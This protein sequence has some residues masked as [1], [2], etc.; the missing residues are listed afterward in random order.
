M[1]TTASEGAPTP[2]FGSHAALYARYRPRYGAALFDLAC[3]AIGPDRRLAVDLGSG[4]GQAVADLLT[5]FERVV[6]VEPDRD[7]ALRIPA[8][9]R[10]KVIQARAEDV[11]FPAGSVDLV[12]SATAFHWME[13][14][15]VCRRAARW[16]RPGGAFVAFAYG[17]A[18]VLAPRDASRLYTAAMAEWRSGV[19]ER[20]VN[21]KAYD[22]AMVEAGAFTSVTAL[23]DRVSF[24]WTPAEA[25]GFFLSTSYGSG[26][27]ASTGDPDA[28][29]AAFMADLADAAPS[30][31][32]DV[33]FEI[34]GAIG[35]V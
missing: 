23:S 9:S 32:I 35:R 33:S 1:E 29:L 22:R 24:H 27:A 5:R 18:Q 30:G 3:E 20:L 7:M 21:W 34:E 10:L 16:L 17:P 6:A 2:R 12:L 8:A 11:D 31:L 4:T 14:T 15:E 26:Y 28:Y 13:Q 19:H 25:A